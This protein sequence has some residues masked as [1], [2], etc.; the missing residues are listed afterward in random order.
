MDNDFLIES[1]AGELDAKSRALLMKKVKRGRGRPSLGDDSA[2]GESGRVNVR[3]P[4]PDLKRLNKMAENEGVNPSDVLRDAIANYVTDDQF[5]R[6]KAEKLAMVTKMLDGLGHTGPAR[7]A[8]I[9]RLIGLKLL[10]EADAKELA[11][12]KPK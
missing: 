11:K 3:L 12:S 4:G 1:E 10:S 6:R 9:Q 7:D 8:A 5:A 2:A